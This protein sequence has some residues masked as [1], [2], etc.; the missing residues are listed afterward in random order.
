VKHFLRATAFVAVVASAFVT[1]A[2][3]ARA[4]DPAPAET[5]KEDGGKDEKKVED[6]WIAVVGGDIHT[7]TGE[8]LKGATILGKN[9]KIHAIGHD[10]DV[11]KDAKVHDVS[12]MRVY[13]GLVAISSQ[14]LLGNAM[15]EFDDTI[16]PFSTRM[17][18]GLAAGITTTGVGG[19]AVKL[20]RFSVDGAVVNER[21]YTVMSWSGRNPRTKSELREKFADAARYIREYREWERKSKEQKDLPEPKKSGIDGGVLS[22]LRGETQ[23]K[24]NAS[25]RDD[26]L[27]IARLAQEY[28]FRPIIDGCQEGWTVADELGRAGA[29]VVLTARDRRTKDEQQSAAGGTSIENAAILHKGGCMVAVTP[30]TEGIDL[31]GLEGRDIRMLT[32]EAGFAVRGGLP[33]KAALEAITI[34]P[35][36]MMGISHRVGSLEVGKDFDLLVTDGDLLHYATYVQWAYVDGRMAYDKEKELYY[37]HIRPRPAAEKKLD[38]GETAEAKPADEPKPEGEKKDGESDAEKK[39]DEKKDA[40]KKDAEK[41]DGEGG[42]DGEKKDGEKKDGEKKDGEKNDGDEK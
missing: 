9:G 12:G 1:T 39:G 20:K 38:A 31:G 18:L 22:V 28:G 14:G 4:Q 11:P 17:V 36:R 35:A 15:A 30:P 2:A 29:R 7:G 6:K 42:G 24:F 40:E 27:G 19:S 26:L 16:D 25:D 3:P 41:K 13:P 37:A 5:K 21:A 10:L 23:A 34:V 33:E 32:I 8:V